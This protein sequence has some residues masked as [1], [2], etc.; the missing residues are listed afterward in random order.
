MADWGDYP[1]E[2]RYKE[3]LTV[4]L[5]VEAGAYVAVVRP[6]G[7]RKLNQ[8]GILGQRPPA[9][10]VDASVVVGD[11]RAVL[12]LRPLV[13]SGLLPQGDREQL[14]FVLPVPASGY[15]CRPRPRATA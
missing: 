1:Q 8:L 2:Y 7:A 5:A 13:G 14:R 4:Q 6:S 15:C 11:R 10:P 12:S 9:K 3:V